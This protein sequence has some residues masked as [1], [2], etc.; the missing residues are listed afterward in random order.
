[1]KGIQVCS[2]K[3]QSH[4]RMG[5][6]HKSAKIRW[7]H[8]NIFFSRTTRPEKLRFTGKH[9]EIHVMQIQ[10]C[11]N[12]SPQESGGAANRKSIFT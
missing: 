10:V 12:H 1:M 2:N 9:F 11:Q 5:D 7:G 4:L 6:N 8:L 3:E